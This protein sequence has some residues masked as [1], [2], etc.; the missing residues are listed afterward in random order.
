[1]VSLLKISDAASIGLHALTLMA[2][3]PN[4]VCSASS[5]AQDLQV[6][7]NHLVKV[8]QR[9]THA[10][11]L[12]ASRGPRGGYRLAKP[13][14]RITLRRV[15][16]ALEG[17][18][19]PIGCLLKKPVCGGNCLLG[20]V[21][22][23]VNGQLAPYFSRTSIGQLAESLKLRRIND[24]SEKKKKKQATQEVNHVLLSM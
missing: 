22:K 11:L 23:V 5:L 9:L 12:C 8:M 10:G 3:E 13:P 24:L 20:P 1:M 17:R 2:A 6:S 19:D 4:R 7:R 14:A 18:I 21:F 15:M 16:E